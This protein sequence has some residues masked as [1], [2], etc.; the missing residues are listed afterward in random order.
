M[1]QTVSSVSVTRSEMETTLLNIEKL[2]E[3]VK[4]TVG[5]SP[6]SKEKYQF[7]NHSQFNVPTFS[8]RKETNS[9]I[10]MPQNGKEINSTIPGIRIF[11]SAPK[12]VERLL[13]PM[14]KVEQELV[15]DETGIA[16]NT[17]ASF[18]IPKPVRKRRSGPG[19]PP[20]DPNAGDMDDFLY[21][22]DIASKRPYRRKDTV[23]CS[24]SKECI[25]NYE[26]CQMLIENL[27]QMT[28]NINDLN[29]RK[30]QLTSLHN[31]DGTSSKLTMKIDDCK[32]CSLLQNANRN[33]IRQGRFL[34]SQVSS[35]QLIQN[36]LLRKLSTH[37][38]RESIIVIKTRLE[39]IRN[40][41]KVSKFKSVSYNDEKLTVD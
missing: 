22:P 38:E 1:P 25:E 40:Q 29:V 24:V 34:E 28:K 35:A 18:P 14:E 30:Q 36:G 11:N 13:P 10:N 6:K 5:F 39:N 33:S 7:A 21:H 8:D 31:C 32:Q 17:C 26:L 4:I 27:K 37:G 3:P 12:L 20:L 9:Q 41:M 19:R 2:N 23:L 15:I 16:F